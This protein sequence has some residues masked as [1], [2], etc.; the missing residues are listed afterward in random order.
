MLTL[1]FLSWNY[2][3][4][5]KSRNDFEKDRLNYIESKEKELDAKEKEINAIEQCSI[6]VTNLENIINNIKSALNDTN[7]V[8]SVSKPLHLLTSDEKKHAVLP[9]LNKTNI[10]KHDIKLDINSEIKP[11]NN[12]EHVNPGFN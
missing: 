1:I 3:K 9:E 11:A 7:L 12:L 8:Y 2:Y 5:L 10:S 4:L 6:K